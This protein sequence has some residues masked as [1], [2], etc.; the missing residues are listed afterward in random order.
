MNEL[1]LW[2]EEFEREVEDVLAQAAAPAPSEDAGLQGE[3]EKARAELEET[4]QALERK[5]VELAEEMRRRSR[6][7]DLALK[8]NWAFQRLDAELQE[9]R[10]ELEAERV[11]RQ[12][13]QARCEELAALLR[14]S[15]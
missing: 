3:L 4:R 12:K 8:L 15:P 2:R 1:R 5:S 10:R 9:A 6:L 7:K 13:V 11:E 14:R